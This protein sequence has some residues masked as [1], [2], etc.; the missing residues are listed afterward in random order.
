M[1]GL[2]DAGAAWFAGRGDLCRGAGAVAARPA[3]AGGAGGDDPQ[4]RLL[5]AFGRDPGW[6]PPAG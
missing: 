2:V 1:A 5:L 3:V 4:A 6:T